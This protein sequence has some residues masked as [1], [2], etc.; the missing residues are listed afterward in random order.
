M[1]VSGHL[2]AWAR[3]WAAIGAVECGSIAASVYFRPS[4]VII[5]LPG[6]DPTWAVAFFAIGS[7]LLFLTAIVRA[8]RRFGIFCFLG[9]ATAHAMYGVGALGY[10]IVNTS[11]WVL[12]SCMFALAGLNVLA[13][14]KLAGVRA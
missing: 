10:A 3:T 12:T 4:P 6:N 2:S 9:A 11:S 1:L 5:Y 13:A 7:G 14:Y 8:P